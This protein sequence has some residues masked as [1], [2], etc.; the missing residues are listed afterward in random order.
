[1]VVN[2]TSFF[3]HDVVGL[4]KLKNQLN[5]ASNLN[6]RDMKVFVDFTG[7]LTS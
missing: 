3:F 5:F 6:Y 4:V 1:M 2:V 7:A